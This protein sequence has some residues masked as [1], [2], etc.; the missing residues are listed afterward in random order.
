MHNAFLLLP[1]FLL[2]VCGY[3]I[4]RYTALDRPIWESVEKLVY[5][6]LFPVLL[7]NSVVRSP[8]QPAATLSLAFCGVAT[9]CVGIALAYALRWVP[10]VDARLHASGAQTAFRFNS[11]VALAL[12]ERL[13][14]AQGVAWVALLVALCVPICNVG[15]VWPLARHGGHDYLRE[16]V[17]NPLIVSTVAGLLANLVGL[18]LPAPAATTLSRIGQAA[19]PLGLMAVGAGLKLGGLKESPGLASA[20]LG[21]RHLL[22]PALALTLGLLLSLPEGQLTILVAF[23]ALPTASSA[24]VLAVRM[25]GHGPYV[26]GLVTVSTLLGMV[27]VPVWMAVLGGVAG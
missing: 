1:D 20:F 8:L 26:A 17:R 5:Y 15:A 23:A 3:L 25:G 18:Q 12:A 22:L 6:L 11:Y 2:I 4:C 21:I 13:A 24:Y 27:S 19:L 16:I 7:F 9:V 10:G 14:G